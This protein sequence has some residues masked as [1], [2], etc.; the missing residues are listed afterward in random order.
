MIS[1]LFKSNQIKAKLSFDQNKF[2]IEIDLND[3]RFLRVAGQFEIVPF[4]WNSSIFACPQ[5][6]YFLLK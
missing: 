1:I 5:S 6:T 2:L 3:V 4:F